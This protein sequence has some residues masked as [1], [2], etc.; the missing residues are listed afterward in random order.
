MVDP[1]KTVTLVGD[2]ERP[3]W[4]LLSSLVGALMCPATDISAGG[5]RE[6]QLAGSDRLKYF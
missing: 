5:F 3:N 4:W 2:G 1:V 6:R